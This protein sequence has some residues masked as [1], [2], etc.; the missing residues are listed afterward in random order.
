[1]EHEFWN[2]RWENN[3]IGFHEREANPALVQ[4]FHA[5]ALAEESRIFLPLCGKTLDIGWLLEMGY[6]VAGA[7]LSEIAIK[8]L[9]EELSVTPEVSDIGELKHYSASNIDIYG[10]DIFNLSAE[11]LGPVD[12]IYDRAALVALPEPMRTRY[13]THLMEITRQ[14]P[15]LL[16]A[17]VYDQ[18]LLPGPPFSV[19]EADVKRYYDDSY[20]LNLLE[21]KA[22]HGGLKGKCPAEECI[23]LLNREEQV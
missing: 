14:A 10:G 6:R 18:S 9:F 19:T 13:T 16:I 21:S 15:Q 2:Q 22:V 7:E 20:Q 4:H 5:L 17:F 1:M 11:I 23:W 3:E 8:Q 12:A